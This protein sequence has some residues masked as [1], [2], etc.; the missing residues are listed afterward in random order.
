[1]EA[2]KTSGGFFQNQVLGM[3]CL[4][5]VIGNLLSVLGLDLNGKIGGSVR[6][7]LYDTIKIMVLL[8]VLIFNYLIHSKLFSAGEKQTDTRKILQNRSKYHCSAAW[9]S[10]TVLFLL[11]NSAVYRIYKRGTAAWRNI[12]FLIS[13]PIVDLGNQFEEY[14][15]NGRSLDLPQ[16]KLQFEDRL[17]DAWEQSCFN[18]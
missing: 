7:F 15:R 6:F 9:N 12:L 10:N 3:K 14:I 11:V 13:S 17:K 5:E 4:N 8:G 1:M 16:E 2:I 18:C